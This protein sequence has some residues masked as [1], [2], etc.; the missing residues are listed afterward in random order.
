MNHQ[1]TQ[2]RLCSSPDL[3]TLVDLGEMPAAN[4]LRR[5]ANEEDRTFPLSVTMCGQCH[6]AQ[7]SITV[8]PGELFDD[9]VYFS[10]FSAS[11]LEHGRRFTESVIAR[12]GLNER[13]LVVEAASNDGYLLQ[14]FQERGIPVLGVEPAANVAKA[15]SEKG[16]FTEVSFF[17]DAVAKDLATRGQ[18]AD[19]LIAN[20]V[21]AHVPDIHDF[22]RGLAAVL[23]PSGVISCEFPHLLPLMDEL[24][25]DTIY[26]EH[27]FYF[28]LKPLIMIMRQYGLEVFDVEKLN[29]HG[30]SLR[31]WAAQKE[32]APPPEA[33]VAK[34][35]AD[36]AAAGLYSNT[37]CAQQLM[38]I[39][40]V[41]DGLCDF[42][43]S[44]HANRRS[45]AGY[46][47][48]AKGNTLLNYCRLTVEE[49]PYVA[50][51]NPHKQGKWLPGSRIPIV[52][53]ERIFSE[54]PDYVLILPWN[55]REEIME[56]LSDIRSWG[57]QFV[58]AI[59]NCVV[60]P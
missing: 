1:I 45:I 42:F 57:G 21:L 43:A 14:H 5:T 41:R 6:L 58:T 35:L 46:G 32:S 13:S 20:N 60:S 37:T 11:W 17:G 15:A 59:P 40:D 55:L 34:V 52:P 49:I 16:I 50:D 30:G 51:L 47:A 48:A 8:P 18:R 54:K 24:Q 3:S 31:L 33:A 2:C 39:N 23:K 4:A 44:A 27:Y 9:Y 7:L 19:L 53:P 56:Q 38:K 25:F 26:H 22:V 29:T 28:S 10:S 12:L 36:E